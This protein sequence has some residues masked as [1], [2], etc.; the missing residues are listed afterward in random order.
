MDKQFSHHPTVSVLVPVC[1]EADFISRCIQAILDNDYQSELVEVLV[2][3]GASTDGT[4]EMVKAMVESGLRVQMI[5][6]PRR[7]V[8]HAMNLGIQA[9]KGEIVIRVDGHAIISPNFI[10]LCVDSL[11][12]H[13]EAW[14]AG[15]P[16]TTI[17]TNIVGR[18]IAGAMS[19]PVGV[20]NAMFR[21]G[22]Y[23]GPVDT[24]AFGAY[25][26]WVFE[27]IGGFDEELVRNQDDELNLRVIQ[28]GGVIYMNPQIR[29]HYYARSSFR[30]LT[31]QYYQYGFWRVRT[32]QKHRKPATIRQIVPLAF[33]LTYALLF[34]VSPLL[35]IALLGFLTLNIIYLFTL[36][37]GA[38]FVGRRLGMAQL[39]LVAWS[40]VLMHFGYGIG[41]GVGIIHFVLLDRQ[42]GTTNASLSR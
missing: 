1:N 20:G 25:W 15:G 12:K 36:L 26:R 32:I 38:I 11:L 23:E 30:K 22:D 6:N 16:V 19:S 24:L 39:P 34:F 7:L 40:Y 9:A 4:T 18:A 8:S 37:G 10:T 42:S 13:P 2:L 17:S 14:C 29:S 3:D 5:S 33:V 21:L 31:K 28:G 35:K 41:C 27:R